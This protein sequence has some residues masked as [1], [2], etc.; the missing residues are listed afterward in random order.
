MAEEFRGILSF[1]QVVKLYAGP[2]NG[3]RLS[4]D[5]R[6]KRRTLGMTLV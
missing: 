1:Q 2:E 3:V 4:L 5:E 6:K